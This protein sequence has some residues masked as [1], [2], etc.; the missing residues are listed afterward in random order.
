VTAATNPLGPAPTT[1]AST[2]GRMPSHWH[3]ASDA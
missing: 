2:P 1:T 3:T